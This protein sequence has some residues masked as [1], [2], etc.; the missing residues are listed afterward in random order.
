VIPLI[1]SLYLHIPFCKAICTYCDFPKLVA[2]GNLQPR[3]T[4][5][6]IGEF[7]YYRNRYDN[8]QTLYIG[9]GTPSS[10]PFPE[11]EKLLDT[12]ASVIDVASLKEYT[13]EAN[14][15]DVTDYFAFIIAKYGVNR[16]SLGVQT[17]DET[18]L[19]NLGRT[20][21]NADVYAAMKNLRHH[22]ITNIN[23]DFI[24]ALPGQTMAALAK[25]V[26]FAIALQPTHLS[27][28]SLILEP[29]TKLFY[30]VTH[31]KTILLDEELE[32]EM[33]EWLMQTLPER[34]FHRY[35][36][37]NYAVEGKTSLHNLAYWRTLPYLGIGMGAHS[38]IDGRRFH[39][40]KTIRAY[41]DS[42]AIHQNGIVSEDAI[43]L[44]LE[45]VFLGLRTVEGIAL[46]A[47][48]ERFG[49]S[50]FQKYPLIEHHLHDGLLEIIDGH[51]KTTARGAL[52][53][54]VVERDLV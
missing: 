25:D 10:L 20:H 9:G 23:C 16:V 53:L 11:L 14:P 37:S 33:T 1:H 32:A 40:H 50:L 29:K 47:Y 30:D 19:K 22:G 36:T 39:N 2:A 54:G 15:N 26:D 35:E 17:S 49:V 8:L 51:L 24:Y 45:T 7:L 3:Y 34:G 4:A 31:Q 44:P 41:L 46:E 28:Y 18:K 52:L 43:D 6:L 21:Q 48:R 5:A 27:F 12:I 42:V 38:Q 13:I